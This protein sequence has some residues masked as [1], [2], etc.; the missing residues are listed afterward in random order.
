MDP[1]SLLCGGV[2]IGYVVTSLCDV[3]KEW[4]T[5][6]NDRRRMKQAKIISKLDDHVGTLHRQVKTLCERNA[7]LMHELE[8]SDKARL[9]VANLYPRNASTGGVVGMIFESR[10]EADDYNDCFAKKRSECIIIA[11]RLPDPRPT[12]EITEAA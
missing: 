10:K 9:F 7:V 12:T 3:A 4:I 2:V 8:L 6:T 11:E 1:I 5:A